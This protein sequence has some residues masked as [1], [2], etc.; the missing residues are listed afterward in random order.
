MLDVVAVALT[1]CPTAP[2]L[3]SLSPAADNYSVVE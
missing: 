3:L 1:W 2:E